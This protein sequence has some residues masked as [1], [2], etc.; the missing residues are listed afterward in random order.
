M[1]S[2]LARTILAKSYDNPHP[3]PQ[4]HEDLWQLCCSDH[5]KVAI[6]APRGH[7]KSTS[8]T[9]SYVIACLVYRERSYVIL[10]SDTEEQ[11]AEFLA[12]IKDAFITNDDLISAFDVDGVI[13]D[14]VTNLIVRFKDGHRFRIIAKGSEQRFRGRKW[15]G[16]RPDLLVIDDAENEEMVDNDDR[17]EK[18][19]KWMQGALLPMGGDLARIRMVGTILH[20][21]S[22]LERLMPNPRHPNTHIEPLKMWNFVD[23]PWAAIKYKAHP[24]PGDFSEITWPEKFTK[25]RLIEE[26]NDYKDQGNPEGYSQEYLNEPIS[27]DNAYFRPADFIE[28]PKEKINS[29]LTYYAGADLAISKSDRAAFTVMYVAGLDENDELQVVHRVKGRWDSLEIINNIFQIATDYELDIFFIEKENIMKS[30]GPVI[31]KEMQ[32]RNKYLTLDTPVP[33]KDKETRNRPLQARM[34]AGRVTF[35]TDN[36]WYDDCK[37]EL[38]RFPKGPFKDDAD[39]LGLIAAGVDKLQPPMTEEELL[40]KEW[41]EEYGD[42]HYMQNAN[43]YTGY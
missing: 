22:M 34:R 16:K 37:Q 30:I 39:A 12:D 24:A 35:H 26:Y 43:D 9:Y 36:D 1:V 11:A 38:R 8:I 33:S 32:E 4:L 40:D 31:E 21:D 17:R 15:N 3:I 41:E 2:G 25:E 6:A 29:Q 42:E 13:K 10:V 18:F 23:R 14:S 28:T 19:R 5:K 7:A 27:D 20:F